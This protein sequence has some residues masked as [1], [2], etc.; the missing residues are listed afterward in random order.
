MARNRSQRFVRPAPRTMVWFSAGFAPIAIASA[1]TLVSSLNAAA[2]LL[3]PF[4]II[5]TRLAI[6]Y[7]S[8][9][10][11]ASESAQGVLSMQVVSDSAVAA[12]IASVPTPLTETDADYFVYEPV[13]FSF[14]FGDATGFVE[15][16][17]DG[18]YHTVDSKAMRKVGLDEDVAMVLQNRAA[19]GASLG[20]EGRFL[21]KLH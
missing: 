4:T 11:A 3:R 14:T 6:V 12:G 21:V 2:L 19:V 20:I 13:A 10:A 8:D 15:E 18:S 5:R 17:G 9:Q 1:A 7:A 16:Q